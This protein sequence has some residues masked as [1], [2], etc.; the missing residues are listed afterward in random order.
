M[1]EAAVKMNN[2]FSV[3]D[4]EEKNEEA[5]ST[6]S[7]TTMRKVKR[8]E[9]V[10]PQVYRSFSGRKKDMGK[11]SGA[12]VKNGM[13]VVYGFNTKGER[14]TLSSSL[15]DSQAVGTEP[16]LVG[17]DFNVVRA[18]Y[19]LVGGGVPE[20]N[21]IIDF[22]ECIRDTG[23]VEH[24]HT[25]NQFTWS[26]NWKKGGMT[27]LDEVWSKQHDGNGLDIL[28]CR[29]RELRAQLRSLNPEFLREAANI[30]DDY[31]KLCKAEF[32]FHQNKSRI[33]W[34]KD[35]DVSTTYFHKSVRMHQSQNR[36]TTLYDQAGNLGGWEVRA[37]KNH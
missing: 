36:I 3:L 30:E 37:E 2:A 31:K 11:S 6:H 27:I 8:V 13:R 22:N 18:M 4:V 5:M 16:S 25:S 24:P 14:R 1:A 19:E 12:G 23:L 34:Y 32:Q 26:R 9:E 28:Q 17:G 15:R 10:Q 21:A 35:G 33:Q 29:Q 7:N 20:N